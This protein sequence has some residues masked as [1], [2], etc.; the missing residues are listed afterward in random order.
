VNGEY[1]LKSAKGSIF[2]RSSDYLGGTNVKSGSID[3]VLTG[4]SRESRIHGADSL[5]EPWINIQRRIETTKVDSSTR[6]DILTSITLKH[7]PLS[8]MLT[9][10]SSKHQLRGAS[11]RLTATTTP[12]T[13]SLRW[14]S[15]PG[16]DI[17]AP[18]QFTVVGA[19]SITESLEATFVEPPVPLR[20][21]KQMSTVSFRTI[22]RSSTVVNAARFAKQ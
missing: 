2:V 11:S 14:S 18:L 8:I 16:P 19:D 22:V 4:W 20:V 15:F 21:E 10:S 13:I 6:F 1:D 3:T 12:R 17:L 9:Y 7:R 5:D